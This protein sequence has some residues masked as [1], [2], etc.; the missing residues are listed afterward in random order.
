M[1]PNTGNPSFSVITGAL[2][3][4][5]A[6]VS[7]TFTATIPS[8]KDLGNFFLATG[9]K[10]TI[11]SDVYFYPIDFDVSYSGATIT[12]TN[13][14]AAAT[15]P[16]GATFR[17]QLNE[18]GERAMLS[19]PM[20]DP[21]SQTHQVNTTSQYGTNVRAKLIPNLTSAYA[22]LITL[23][24]PATAATNNILA[25]QSL[26]SSGA[27]T[28]NGV[29]ATNGVATLDQPRAIR[30]VSGGAD[31]AVITF[32]GTDVY[33]RTMVEN[34][35][36]N[37]T[38]SVSGKKA[39]KTVTAARASAAVANNITAGTTDIL[40]L[41][42]FL[43]SAAN[44]VAELRGGTK[45]STGGVASVPFT[46]SQ[47]DL[48]AHTTQEI[49]SPIAGV[50]RRLSVTN[51]LTVV[52]GGVIAARVGATPVT[53]LSVTVADAS[54]P[55]A[56]KTTAVAPTDGTDAVAAGGRL[57]ITVGASFAT[58]GALTGN[59]TVSGGD[60]TIVAGVT[61][62]G[63]ATATTGDVRGTY[64][65]SVACNGADVIQLLI[66]LPDRSIGQPHFAG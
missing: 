58:S 11:G 18:Q 54:A 39:F 3:S 22:D 30:I 8:G 47:V 29:L 13:K 33:G 12:V 16:A 42:I 9:H 64:T 45:L 34:I 40:G 21:N 50:V 57:S 65:P 43:P 52:T 41:P 2:A 27:L 19:V 35:T 51:Q 59:V 44:I 32:T 62:A 38:T 60:G 5:V 36:L 46:V 26:A 56:T 6:A 37:G 24:A 1:V 10:L 25:S 49:V 63:G 20:Q 66:I 53:G 4:A 31:T 61:T 55:G 14:T 23:G 48:L 15:W 17:L 28:V 7:G